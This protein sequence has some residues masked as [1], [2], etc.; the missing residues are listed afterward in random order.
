MAKKQ[1]LVAATVGTVAVGAL[2]YLGYRIIKEVDSMID[3]DIWKDFDD[4]FTY[5]GFKDDK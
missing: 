5:R 1:H 2:I 4:A 3:D